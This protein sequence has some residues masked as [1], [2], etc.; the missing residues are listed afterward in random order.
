MA[1]HIFK[2]RDALGALESYHYIVNNILQTTRI[3]KGADMCALD[4]ILEH[5]ANELA[6]AQIAVDEMEGLA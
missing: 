2:L 4:L 1:D 5:M 3:G 6:N